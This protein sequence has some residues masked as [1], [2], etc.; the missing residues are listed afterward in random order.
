[1]SQAEFDKAAEEVK[2]LKTKP[3]DAEMLEIYS[4]Y[5]QATVGDVNTARPG[6]LDF[7]GKAKWDAWEK[8]KGMSKEDAM[9][10]YIAKCANVGI[11]CIEGIDK[12]PMTAIK[13]KAQGAPRLQRART[14]FLEGYSRAMIILFTSL[15]VVLS[16]I[17]V[18]DG[19][20]LLADGQTFGLWHFCS[21]GAG[22]GTGSGAVVAEVGA[23]LNCTARLSLAGVEGLEV[24]LS[25]CRSAASLA[26]VAAIFGVELL[27]LSQI[28]G[29]QD[30]SRRWALGSAL[31][32][33]AFVLSVGGVLVFVV[34]L[35]AHASP[36]GFT[37][38]FWCQFT[39]VFLFFLNGTAA[40]HIH[41]IVLPPAGGP[42]KC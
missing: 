28:G 31:V 33:V 20:W 39:A 13:I 14:P 9:K 24:G 22:G 29:D 19:H 4:L 8:R 37:N 23:P 26:V 11:V 2:V 42:G 32:L 25:F 16:A 27:L 3:N 12:E 34:L 38:A 21:A 30:S 35:R 5:K 7:T 40:R 6:M 18:C 10:A 36:L 17:A 1:M 41:H 15:A